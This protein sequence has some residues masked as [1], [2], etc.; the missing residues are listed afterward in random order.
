MREVISES[1]IFNKKANSLNENKKVKWSFS[2]EIQKKGNQQIAEDKLRNWV[3]G[4]YNIKNEIQQE[5]LK[6]SRDVKKNVKRKIYLEKNMD[7][8]HFNSYFLTAERLW[9]KNGC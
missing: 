7:F 2:F 1:L 9:R 3:G 5:N 8:I 4:L 6:K